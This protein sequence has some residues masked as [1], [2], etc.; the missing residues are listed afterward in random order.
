MSH[1]SYFFELSAISLCFFL[2]GVAGGQ[3]WDHV[4]EI[5]RFRHGI[6]CQRFSDKPGKMNSNQKWK[7]SK[8]LSTN[9][10]NSTGLKSK[11]KDIV[12]YLPFQEKKRKTERKREIRKKK[13][14]ILMTN[15]ESVYIFFYLTKSHANYMCNYI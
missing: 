14:E 4:P 5:P 3:A 9:I 13:K 11:P 1:S 7:V 6:R 15:K 8:Q 12:L 10:L 2:L